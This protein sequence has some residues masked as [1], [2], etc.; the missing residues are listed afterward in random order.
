LKT[1]F[2]AITLLFFSI[3]ACSIAR[4]QGT[5]TA[6]QPIHI[7]VFGAATGTYTGLDGGKNLGITAGA[8]V[9]WK[10]FYG[11]YPSIEVRGTYPVD[12][13]QVDAQKNILAGLKLEKYYGR[14]HPYGDI[15]FGRDKID[16]KSPGYPNSTGTLLYIDSISNVI[17]GGGGLDLSVTDHIAL[18]F[19]VQIQRY[20]VPVNAA[21]D[22]YST[23]ISV[24]I[25]YRF[26]APP[27]ER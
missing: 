9:S 14:L 24:G 27:L 1:G 5:A 26:G 22:I 2:R 8:D 19:D 6:A 25:V 7:S 16:Y 13:G 10:P 17:S 23:P 15:L 3:A 21:G 11:L 4:A 12:G 18:K 20:G